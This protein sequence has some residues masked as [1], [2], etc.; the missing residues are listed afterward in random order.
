MILLVATG[1]Q[2]D[3]SCDR[4]RARQVLWH[5]RTAEKQR[6]EKL[7][8]DA[9]IKLLVVVSIPFGSSGRAMMAELIIG[10]TRPGRAGRRC[11]WQPPLETARLSEALTGGSPTTPPSADPVLHRIDAI[12]TDIATAQDR[13]DAKGNAGTGHGDSRIL[14]H[15][16][17]CAG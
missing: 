5:P 6:V 7:L 17:E 12:T 4:T 2:H 16:G 3:L 11:P 15:R 10:L 8:E 1:V 13:I 14:G 9:L